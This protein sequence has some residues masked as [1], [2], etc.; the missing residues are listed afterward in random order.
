MFQCPNCRAYTDLNAEVDDSNDYEFADA[1]STRESQMTPEEPR[2]DERGESRAEGQPE[3][4]EPESR[5]ESGAS[6]SEAGS[7]AEPEAH[8]SESENH[9]ASE[10]PQPGHDATPLHPEGQLDA[11][12]QE[13][14]S[15]AE[16]RE[17]GERPEQEEQSEAQEPETPADGRRSET[18]VNPE[19]DLSDSSEETPA[20][21]PASPSVP[22]LPNQFDRLTSPS[23]DE[24]L[25]INFDSIQL[26]DG[27]AFWD[28]PQGNYSA[29]ASASETRNTN[30][31]APGWQ[32]LN[33]IHQNRLG[34]DTPGRSESS[35]ENPLTPRNDTGPL[36][37]DGRAGVSSLQ[38]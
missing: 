20:P 24:A 11:R 15:S 14:R 28:A 31:P 12:E 6:R 4:V 1:K 2:S 5:P 30:S 16:G 19:A 13:S 10:A 3:P 37:F 36:A 22:V 23:L 32:S 21:A 17:P 34:S 27:D 33:H 18:P 35:E 29:P 38:S 8:Q 9:D 26:Q 7:R 25:A